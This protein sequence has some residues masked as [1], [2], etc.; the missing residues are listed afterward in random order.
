[1]DRSVVLGKSTVDWGC[2]VVSGVIVSGGVVVVAALSLSEGIVIAASSSAVLAIGFGVIVVGKIV[3]VALSSSTR[4]V[5][6]S[7]VDCFSA[8]SLLLL[9]VGG[10]VFWGVGFASALEVLPLVV[11]IGKIVVASSSS[12]RGVVVAVVTVFVS[13]SLSLFLVVVVVV[14]EVEFTSALGVG[15]LVGDAQHAGKLLH[16]VSLLWHVGREGSGKTKLLHILRMSSVSCLRSCFGSGK[17]IGMYVACRAAA[18]GPG[19]SWSFVVRP[20]GFAT[21]VP[22]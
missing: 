8:S 13:S 7:V 10:V 15:S 11:V 18:L 5:V 20:S 22:L 16:A 17:P 19:G 2:V 4:G 3:I 12:V 21:A 9:L 6:F 14:S 1:V